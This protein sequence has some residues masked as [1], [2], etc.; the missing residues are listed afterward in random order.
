MNTN[1]KKNNNTINKTTATKNNRPLGTHILASGISFLNDTHKTKTN[2]NVLV[3]G[4]SGSGKTRH[5][6]TP[7]ILNSQESMV[8]S[9]TKG[10]LIHELGPHLKNM[11]FTVKC[12]DFAE[13]S[14]DIGYNPLDYIRYDSERDRY[15]EQDVLSLAT[16][17]IPDSNHTDR[18][19]DMAARQFLSCLI[20]YVLETN[21][22]EEHTIDKAFK[23]LSEMNDNEFQAK[24][25]E[26]ELLRPWS[27]TASRYRALKTMTKADRMNASI[28]GIIST[29]LDPLCF[30]KALQL[31][32]RPERICF[33]SLS[34]EKTA[35]FLTISDTDRS[36]D[37]LADAFMTQAIQILSKVA[38][39]NVE[40]HRLDIPVRFYLDD[41]ATNLYIPNFDKIVSVIRSREI[42]VS[43]ILQSLSQLTSLYGEARSH[44][45]M[46]NCDHMVYL[47]GQDLATAHYIAQRTDK[48]MSKI[49]RMPIDDILVLN[50]GDNPIEAKKYERPADLEICGPF[51]L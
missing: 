50:R 33:E 8:I 15:D 13:F 21:P 36:M 30:D 45:I 10:S 47:G 26:L 18:Y 42:S 38:D 31:Y 32:K 23:L 6:V 22:R 46:N 29:N 39:R 51:L 11:G 44:T 24:M 14:G 12:V 2:N 16:C 9:D 48:P 19:W 41:F 37:R 17:L 35:L 7:N 34:K 20:S 49:L 3:F 4:P 25:D 27:T 1:K 43:I 28:R 40:T 5:Y